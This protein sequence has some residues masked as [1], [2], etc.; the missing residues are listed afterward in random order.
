ML[1]GNGTQQAFYEDRDVLF[2][3]IHQDSNYP[4]KRGYIEEDGEGPGKSFNINVPLPPGSG[5]GAYSSAIERVVVPA[6]EA[7]KPELLLVSSGF[8][9][10]FMDPLG[11]MMLSSEHFRFIA[12]KLIDT[13]K[14]L[15][16]GRIVFAHEVGS[17]ST[18]PLAAL[19]QLSPTCFDV[20]RVVTPISTCLSAAW[21]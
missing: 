21:L 8:D 2:I 17:P 7:F 3:S 4:V 14:A 5:G 15:C 18:P 20:S 6:L 16:N 9:A 13:S 10:A 12:R 19:S 11:K 1:T